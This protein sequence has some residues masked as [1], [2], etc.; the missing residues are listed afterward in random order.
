MSS[1]GTVKRRRMKLGFAASRVVAKTLSRQEM[2]DM[3]VKEMNEDLSRH[4]G[5]RTI[6]AKVA[7]NSETHIPRC[8]DSHSRD[9]FLCSHCT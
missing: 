6:T 9:I 1:S 2:E 7:L 4:S 3:V 8:V 5:V